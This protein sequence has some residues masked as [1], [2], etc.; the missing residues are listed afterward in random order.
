MAPTSY[1][2]AGPGRGRAGLKRGHKEP[3]ALYYCEVHSLYI[4]GITNKTGLR[5]LARRAGIK[6]IS[7]LI[8]LEDI[9]KLVRW[10]IDLAFAAGVM[11]SQAA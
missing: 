11:F 4:D 5:R 9:K 7:G 2:K 1:W 3:C 8:Y 10:V 6:R